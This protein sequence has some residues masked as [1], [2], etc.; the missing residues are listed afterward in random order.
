MAKQSKGK[1]DGKGDDTATYNKWKTLGHLEGLSE[2]DGTK[3]ALLM[4]AAEADFQKQAE[5]SKPVS[6]NTTNGKINFD[7]KDFM[8]KSMREA[9]DEKNDPDGTTFDHT[10]IWTEALAACSA[11]S[12]KHYG[13]DGINMF[14][15]TTHEAFI[16]KFGASF[17]KDNLKP[18]GGR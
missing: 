16:A 2:A 18:P 15:S 1:G 17:S 10:L 4:E 13:G 6:I 11:V 14:D 3:L 8:Y 5:Y 9:F 7:M 12:E